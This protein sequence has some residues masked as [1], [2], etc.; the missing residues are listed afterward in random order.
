MY[1]NILMCYFIGSIESM[2]MFSGC[3]RIYYHPDN[4]SKFIL[5]YTNT[6]LHTHTHTH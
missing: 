1:Y 2:S 6:P 4:V 3:F 5:Y